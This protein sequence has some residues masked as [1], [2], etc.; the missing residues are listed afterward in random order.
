LEAKKEALGKSV[1][2]KILAAEEAEEGNGTITEDVKEE[3][4]ADMA[5]EAD[6]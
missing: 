6:V 4:P 2:E 1:A 3:A 5:S